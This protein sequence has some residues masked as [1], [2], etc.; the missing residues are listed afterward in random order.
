MKDREIDR[1]TLLKV[2]GGVAAAGAVA[3]AGVVS[4]D[5]RADAAPATFTPPG[6][7]HNWGDLNRGRRSGSPPVTT[8]GCRAGTG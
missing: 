3:T 4:L 7:L 2:A 8:R 1:R 5:R 6:G